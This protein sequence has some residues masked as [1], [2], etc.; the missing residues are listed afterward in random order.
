MK[1][2]SFL[3]M[4][5]LMF[6]NVSSAQ[7]SIAN[8]EQQTL[9]Y[10][11]DIS[12]T[13]P[14]YVAGDVVAGTFTFHN[15]GNEAVTSARYRIELVELLTD[16]QG[17][18]PSDPLDATEM[19]RIPTSVPQ[20][21]L[22]IP[23]TYNLPAHIP[24]GELGFLVEAYS[25]DMQTPIA[26]EVV[27]LPVTGDR[28]TYLSR[29][30]TVVVNNEEFYEVLAGPMVRTDETAVLEVYVEHSE[31]APVTIQPRVQI[32]RGRTS[33]GS[34]V[35]TQVLP[36]VT[37]ASGAVE[38]IPAAIPLPTLTPDVYTVIVTAVNAATGVPAFAPVE[39]RIIVEGL[40]PKI[41]SVTY[42]T[43]DISQPGATFD[44]SVTYLDAPINVRTNADGTPQDE[45]VAQALYGATTTIADWVA[46]TG[47]SAVV[48]VEDASTQALL[49]EQRIVF[50]ETNKETVQFDTFVGSP[51]VTVTVELEQQGVRVDTHQETLTLVV[52]EHPIWKRLWYEHPVAVLTVGIIALCVIVLGVGMLAFRRRS[53]VPPLSS[54]A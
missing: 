14:S 21:P 30:G 20:T 37:I 25:G 9:F 19:V 27:P 50:T 8:G 13:Q 5:A 39:A 26:L 17:T 49:G 32:V 22:T 12:F 34:V 16:E 43:L 52:P 31:S 1:Y 29:A 35:G 4:C 48:R 23:F 18:Y 36:Q 28:V 33:S 6:P 54:V 38:T 45:R 10:V 53:D 24:G 46:A 51:T 41:D 7:S 15:L 42:R 2:I 11:S 44:V 47:M 40:T 3:L